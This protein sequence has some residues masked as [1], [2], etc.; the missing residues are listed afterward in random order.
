MVAEGEARTM[1]GWL[2]YGAALNEGR[3]LH[4]SNNAFHEWLLFHQLGGT[5]DLDRAAAMWAAAHGDTFTAT[6]KGH[7]QGPHGAG[8]PRQVEGGPA[9][10]AQAYP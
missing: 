3:K 4:P 10:A 1:D 7:P 9:A 8:S 6:R 5:H 2:L